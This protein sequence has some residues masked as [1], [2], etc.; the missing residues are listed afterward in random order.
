[1]HQ[2]WC[3]SSHPHTY[4]SHDHPVNHF[5]PC[6]MVLSLQFIHQ[7]N[8]WIIWTVPAQWPTSHGHNRQ[9]MEIYNVR[10]AIEGMVVD[11]ALLITFFK[12]YLPFFIVI[13]QFRYLVKSSLVRHLKVCGLVTRFECTFCPRT[14][15]YSSTVK[16]H[17][18]SMHQDRDEHT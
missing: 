4:T 6:S 7:T 12:E 15:A 3:Q 16:R 2:T 1:M 5:Q 9:T 13:L 17:M 14:F 8:W 18:K 10:D 11:F